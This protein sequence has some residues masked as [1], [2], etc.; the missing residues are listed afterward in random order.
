MNSEHNLLSS[1]WQEL[2]GHGF[3]LLDL[4]FL[5]VKRFFF[6]A[7]CTENGIVNALLERTLHYA[8]PT[9][10]LGKLVTRQRIGL[11]IVRGELGTMRNGKHTCKRLEIRAV[12]C[13]D[14]FPKSL[15]ALG[16]G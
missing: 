5:L 9:A 6:S 16:A 13:S 3:L 2:Q 14:E 11:K 1:S 10:S 8:G 4:R 12:F 15:Q 7:C